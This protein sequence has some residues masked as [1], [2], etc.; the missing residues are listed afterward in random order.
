MRHTTRLLLLSLLVLSLAGCHQSVVPSAEEQQADGC[1]RPVR[2]TA[3]I[4]P[5]DAPLRALGDVKDDPDDD[6][7]TPFDPEVVNPEKQ[8]KESRID[9]VM[10][11][12]YDKDKLIRTI[13]YKN[14]TITKGMPTA[15]DGLEVKPFGTETGGIFTFDLLLSPGRYRFV[16]LVNDPQCYYEAKKGT[17]RDPQKIYL[18]QMTNE[19]KMLS[20]QILADSPDVSI[21]KYVDGVQ[22]RIIPMTGQAMLTIP[23]GSDDGTITTVTPSIDLERVFARVELILTTATKDK[24]KFLSPEIAKY[25]IDNRD[26]VDGSTS[27]RLTK[28]RL[29]DLVDTDWRAGTLEMLPSRGEYTATG[30]DMPEESRLYSDRTATDYQQYFRD[31]ATYRAQV[32]TPYAEN[33]DDMNYF[34]EAPTSSLPKIYHRRSKTLVGKKILNWYYLYIPPMFIDGL[35]K[36]DMP[37]ILIGINTTG[38]D[39]PANAPAAAEQMTY[40]RLPITTLVSAAGGGIEEKFEVRR[41]T[42]Y[43]IYAAFR[44]GRL[45][46]N[47]GIKVYPWRRVDQELPIDPDAD[48]DTLPDWNK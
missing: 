26:Y 38:V 35:K 25:K 8:F 3:R 19:R 41:N 48:G 18:S 24:S 43:S 36:E 40:F 7:D 21:R 9:H 10:L 17:I 45:I 12:V 4:L 34:L 29:V 20:S 44:G 1:E 16:M 2:I 6:P 5:S 33:I 31:A 13:F 14:P 37:Y 32:T 15:F 47:D 23:K 30:R 42:T 46:L 28:G 39:I 22:P 27:G 11:Y